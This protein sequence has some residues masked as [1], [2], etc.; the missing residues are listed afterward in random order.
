M[1]EAL[2]PLLSGL[3]AIPG[4]LFSLETKKPATQ[5]ETLEAS[6]DEK[7][8]FAGVLA[9]A[10]SSLLP[11]LTPILVV[12]FLFLFFEG[13]E[14]SGKTFLETSSGAVVSKTFFDFVALTAIGKARSGAVA[15]ASTELASLG[16]LLTALAAGT[17]ALFLAIALLLL[18]YRKFLA[19]DF[20]GRGMK[21]ALL[22]FF[23]L[24]AFAT[25]G[26]PGI[27]ILAVSASV[28]ITVSFLGVDKST[29]VGCLIMPSL[30]FYFGIPVF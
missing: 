24:A 28:G 20:T 27:L 25:G 18:F 17:A 8:V 3:F 7:N 2:V 16:G 1:R 21:L 11:A 9:G 15:F 30:A 29:N 22:A 5:N 14:K 23:S 6:V 26:A 4:L 12:S 19:L 10:F 13:R